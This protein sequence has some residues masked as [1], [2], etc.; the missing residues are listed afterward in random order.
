[1]LMQTRVQYAFQ[2]LF[3]KS[4]TMV[5]KMIISLQ[6]ERIDINVS[7]VPLFLPLFFFQLDVDT[8]Q[9]AVE[10]HAVNSAAGMLMHIN[11]SVLPNC[12]NYESY[13]SLW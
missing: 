6:K 5:G 11:F 9:L 3:S 10:D 8:R 7:H 2:C 4:S 13:L 12:F 1:M